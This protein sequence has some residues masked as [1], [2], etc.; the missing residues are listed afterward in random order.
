MWPDP[1][2][3]ALAEIELGEPEEAGWIISVVVFGHL[4]TASRFQDH[5]GGVQEMVGP[6]IIPSLLIHYTSS[7][8]IRPSKSFGR[9][10]ASLMDMRLSKPLWVLG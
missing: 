5:T 8:R 4:P 10:A 9:S 2:S 6:L 7:S 1:S 3:H